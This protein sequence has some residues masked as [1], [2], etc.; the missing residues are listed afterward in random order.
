MELSEILSLLASQQ[1]D[2][3]QVEKLTE[4]I[5]YAPAEDF[6]DLINQR[7]T[8]LEHA[9]LAEN[10]LKQ[11]GSGDG[12]LRSV[13]NGSAEPGALSPEL[14]EVYETS[15]RVKAALC[16]IRRLE[17]Q[18]VT[19]MENERAEAL[20]HLEELNASS[21]SAAAGYSH[22]LRTAVPPASFM[23]TRSV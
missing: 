10:R 16:R 11:A 8:F 2:L 15:L 3:V 7:G 18:V 19:R 5:L 20:S 14:R 12:S 1:S 22:V 17:P 23:G 4:Q 9:V 13:L 21:N 6:S